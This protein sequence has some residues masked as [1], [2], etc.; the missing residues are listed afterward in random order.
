MTVFMQPPFESSPLPA[1]AML[2]IIK[3]AIAEADEV[4]E[5]SK[6]LSSQELREVIEDH[7]RA[8]RETLERL[9]KL[10]N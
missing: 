2:D 8:Q 4:I 10:W 1:R 9:L 3:T 7:A 5:E 6:K